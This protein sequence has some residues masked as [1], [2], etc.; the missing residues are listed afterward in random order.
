MQL[1][2]RDALGLQFILFKPQVASKEVVSLVSSGEHL[3]FLNDLREAA[4]IFKCSQ[5]IY[6]K[7]N[8]VPG[9][10]FPTMTSWMDQGLYGAFFE[11]S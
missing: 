11:S 9:V 10:V 4:V 2:T 5:F 1:F 6:G 7:R 3:G 8:A